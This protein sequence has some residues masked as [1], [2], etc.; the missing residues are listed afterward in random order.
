MAISTIILGVVAVV[1]IYL[2]WKWWFSSKKSA[3]LISL[4]NAKS[5]H[6]IGA[7]RLGKSTQS[8]SY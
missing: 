2:V 6:R 5:E 4:H 8:Y 3:A 7:N 1:V